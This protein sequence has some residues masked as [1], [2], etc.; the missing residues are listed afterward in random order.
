MF[1]M[2]VR[3]EAGLVLPQ[4]GILNNTDRVACVPS[5]TLEYCT[6]TF[7]PQRW[8][9]DYEPAS[10]WWK[11]SVVLVYVETR[12]QFLNIHYFFVL[13]A[14]P[15]LECSTNTKCLALSTCIL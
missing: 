11:A 9:I 13:L 6:V 1:D 15:P 2:S 8:A 14:N 7:S 4:V 10:I 3:H 12:E 5:Y